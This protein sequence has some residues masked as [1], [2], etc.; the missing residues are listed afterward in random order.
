M[1]FT[2]YIHAELLI[3]VP[4]LYLIGVGLKKSKLSDSRIPLA[5]GGISVLLC[6]IWVLATEAVSGLQPFCSALF[7]AI[8]QGILIAGASVYSNQLYKQFQKDNDNTE[9]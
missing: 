6:S 1:D 2:T 8:T 7:T 5:L 4:V 9:E 3:L